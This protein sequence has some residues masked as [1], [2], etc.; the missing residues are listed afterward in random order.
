MGGN[1]KH[2]TLLGDQSK[3]LLWLSKQNQKNAEK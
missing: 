2:T 1:L 3:H